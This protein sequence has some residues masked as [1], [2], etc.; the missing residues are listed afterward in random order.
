MSEAKLQGKVAL[1]TGAT[2]GIGRQQ[3]L[4]LASA[5]CSVVACGRREDRL[6]ALADQV[7]SAGG[8]LRTLC[9]DLEQREQLSA[10]AD[11][12]AAAFGPV[13]ILCNTAGVNFREAPDAISL[14][15]WDPVSYTHL[16]LPTIYSV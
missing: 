1:I 6:Q 5:G 16:T 9:A 11:D 14:E 13:D 7:T 3:A 15:S 10:I 8:Q 12:A 2:S 4:A